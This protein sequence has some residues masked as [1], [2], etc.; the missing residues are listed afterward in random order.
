MQKTYSVN[1]ESGET[2]KLVG[3]SD[4]QDDVDDLSQRLPPSRRIASISRLLK[5]VHP[6]TPKGVHFDLEEVQHDGSDSQDET[7]DL[8]EEEDY[9]LH[10]DPLTRENR[11]SQRA[12]LLM[13]I[14]APRVAVVNTNNI[15]SLD[16]LLES[17]R[18]RSGILSA[19]MN[20]ANSIMYDV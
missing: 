17:A 14:E 18:P 20:M 8:A 9:V 4:S 15:T 5:K 3:A 13:D 16:Y 19:F 2:C 10:H 1:D 11:T 6:R 7:R 12:P